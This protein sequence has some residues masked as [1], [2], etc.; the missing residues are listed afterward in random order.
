MNVTHVL[1]ASA[2]NGLAAS[3]PDFIEIAIG[4]IA[5]L[6]DLPIREAVSRSAGLDQ[7]VASHP[8]LAALNNCPTDRCTPNQLVGQC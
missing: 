8:Q 2:R 7:I 6:A 4:G 3:E 1:E 5:R